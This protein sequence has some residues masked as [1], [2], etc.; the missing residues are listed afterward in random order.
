VTGA[1]EPEPGGGP[2]SKPGGEPAPPS[3]RAPSDGPRAAGAKAAARPSLW[4]LLVVAAAGGWG[5][6]SWLGPRPNGVEAPPAQPVTAPVASPLDCPAGQLPDDGVCI[7]VPSAA[8]RVAEVE[9]RLELLPGRSPD[10]ARY[11]TPI[12]A[13]RAAA[14]AEGLGIFVPAPRGVPVTAISL[15]AQTGPTRRWVTASSPPRLLTAHRVDRAGSLRTYLLVYDGVA[16][17][18]APGL[19]DVEVGTPLGRVAPAR[20][21]TGLGLRVHQLRRGV[22][23]EDAAPERLLLDTSSLVCDARNVLPLQPAP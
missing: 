23:V 22:N 17:D 10:Y 21:A 13:Y 4:P 11:I 2:Q 9:T 16:F 19:T 5:A 12:A 18:P 1:P 20:G 3:T 8:E 15:E 7:P 14:P 6:W